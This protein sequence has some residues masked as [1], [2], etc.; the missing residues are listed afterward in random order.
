MAD[1]FAPASAAEIDA[2]PGPSVG[3][4]TRAER[5]AFPLARDVV[6]QVALDHGA[7]I[8]LVQLR[9]T[10]LD[11]G[12]VEQVMVPC[13]ATLAS[14]CPP[15][16]ERN[17]ILRAAQCRDGWHLEDEP[18]MTP[19]PPDD[20]YQKCLVERLA[21]LYAE[22]YQAEATGEDTAEFDDLID[23]VQDE[24]AATG[25]RGRPDPSTRKNGTSGAGRRRRRHRSTRRRQDAP[26]LP[27]RRLQLD[28]QAAPA[29]RLMTVAEICAELGGLS[30]RTFYRWRELG[31]GPRC[32]KIPNGELRVWR[33]E[34]LA[35]GHSVEILYRVYAH[36]LDD[37][38][39]RWYERMEQ[40][41]G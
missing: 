24:L 4:R 6:K 5:L 2:A 11:T 29:G 19:G 25:V 22:R 7:C 30:C 9:K 1:P 32:L 33:S 37:E 13:G 23:A 36:C 21:D 34:F 14:I 16:A 41:L 15:C 17:K 31:V 39:D 40:A 28:K 38:D 35:A 10:N 26:G 27:K 3:R 8:R 18:I 12:E 20:Y